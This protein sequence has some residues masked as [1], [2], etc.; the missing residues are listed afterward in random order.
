[1]ESLT[2]VP[3][4]TKSNIRSEIEYSPKRTIHPEDCDVELSVYEI[5]AL[6]TD[7]IVALGK[8]KYDYTKYGVIFV[9]IYFV[10]SNSDEEKVQIGVYEY[11]Q[12][13]A[14]TLLDQEG[15][16]DVE[17]LVPIFYPFAESIVAH[18]SSNVTEYLSKSPFQNLGKEEE[19]E[20]KEKPPEEPEE[21]DSDEEDDDVVPE[22]RS[23]TDLAEGVTPKKAN[24]FT[25]TGC[26]LLVNRGQFGPEG[27]LHCPVGEAVCPAIEQL[28]SSPPV[29]KVATAKAN[30]PAKSSPAKAAAPA[31]KA[32][33]AK[34]AAPVK[35]ASPRKKS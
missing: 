21:E 30:P 15:D 28:E 16:L 20:E 29:V 5:H 9:P 32:A 23:A 34:K 2:S 6:N 31:K 12:E 33:A 11:E 26:F 10:P 8:P 24:E 7:F 27:A 18:V 17:S 22:T 3:T 25:C 13:R 19:E 35:K 4:P 1:M 14:I